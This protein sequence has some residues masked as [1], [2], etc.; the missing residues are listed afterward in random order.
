MNR[1]FRG[2]TLVEVMLAL[3]LGAI[4]LGSLIVVTQ[5][6]TGALRQAQALDLLASTTRHVRAELLAVTSGAGARRDPVTQTALAAVAGSRSDP[7]GDVL[8]LQA[9]TPRNCFDNDNPVRG[10]EGLPAWWLQRNEYAVRDGW[11][12]VR[13]CTYGPP[14]SHG[15]RQLNAATLVEGVEALRLRF[16]LDSDGDRRLDRWVSAAS[17]GDESSV[18]G[19]RVGLLLAT[20]QPVG[21]RPQAPLELFGEAITVP[22][23]GRA[24]LAAMLTLPI[25]GRL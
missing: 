11:R 14:G 23:D 3:T 4:V 12:L 16:G 19:V 15:I 2:F 21:A 17:V 25:R 13:R 9:L 18:I 8:V 24:R 22:T 7:T 6:V 10:P 1:R 20:E 5:G